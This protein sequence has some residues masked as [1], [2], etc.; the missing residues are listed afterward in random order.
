M[1]AAM[2]RRDLFST[3]PASI[4]AAQQASAQVNSTPPATGKLHAGAASSNITPPLGISLDGPISQNG[5]ALHVHDELHARCLVLD[6]GATRIAIAICDSTMLWQDLIDEAKAIASQTT[7]LPA[8]HML[9]AATHTHS[10]PRLGV[11]NGE[12]ERWY[13]EFLPRRIADG[14][15][16]AFNNLA[17]ARIGWGSARV[18][19]FVFNRRWF[20]KA[21]SIPPNP[22]GETGDRIQ[23][24]PPAG[25]PGLIRPA[26]PVDPEMF[27]VSLRHAD[28]RPLALLANYGLHY[29]GGGRQ[30]DIS[31]DYFGLFS[32]DVRDLLASEHPDMPFVAMMSNGTSGD[33]NSVD[34]LSK[35]ARQPPYSRMREVAH[36]LAEQAV[37]IAKEAQ[38]QA[39]IS[40]AAAHANLELEIRRPDEQRLTW[41]RD[42]WAQAQGAERLTRPQVYARETLALADYPPVVK[43]PMQAFRIGA[44]GLAAIPCEVFAETGLA[45]K[46]NSALKPAFTIELANGYFGYLPTA[47]QHKSGGY[48]TW[49]ARSSCLETEAETKIRAQALHLLETVARTRA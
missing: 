25:S 10:T 49:P 35:R 20:V 40:L 41:A 43:I 31:A 29:V 32:E 17:P 23:M 11:R 12:I 45:I 4:A 38:Y 37:R 3:F 15:I 9:I 24:N 18:P 5:P 47:Q 44:L 30:G 8:E 36:S 22:F 28:G 48:E 33:V 14:I 2:T 19:E 42:L 34:F 21:E 27:V 13:R 16:R 7:G 26:G 39:G 6:D 1:I 46:Q